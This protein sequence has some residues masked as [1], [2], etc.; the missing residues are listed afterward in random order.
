MD[1]K[2]ILRLAR[3]NWQ[4]ILIWTVLVVF[5]WIFV[6]LVTTGYFDK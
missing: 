2:K 6:I 5:G 3:K 1:V 4:Q